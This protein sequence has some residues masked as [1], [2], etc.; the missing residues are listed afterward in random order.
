[1]QKRRWRAA[2]SGVERNAAAGSPCLKEG[3]C[4]AVML[5][6]MGGKAG[7]KSMDNAAAS[8]HDAP[9]CRQNLLDFNPCCLDDS[10]PF[11]R[12]RFQKL[13][14]LVWGGASDGVRIASQ[15]L[16]Q[17]WFYESF[18]KITTY[19]LH[20]FIGRLSWRKDA[21]PRV[22]HIAWDTRL[23]DGRHIR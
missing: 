21:L 18:G 2:N 8:E 20:D 3:L 15:L 19:L 11:P 7:P 13:R 10:F 22:D 9:Q 4:P 16:D 14:K 23:G 17:R 6:L 1:A 12:I 5:C